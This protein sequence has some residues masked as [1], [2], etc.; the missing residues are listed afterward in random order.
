MS[1]QLIKTYFD[2]R[3][4]SF[5]LF[6]APNG[7]DFS[8]EAEN[9]DNKYTIQSP[10]M[11]LNKGDTLATKF[12]PLRTIV[13]YVAFKVSESAF[14]KSYD[15]AQTRIENIIRDLHSVSNYRGDGIKAVWFSNSKVS[16]VKDYILGEL[17]FTVE[18]QL[19]YV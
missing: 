10:L 17:T 16:T 15:A 11:D 5:L 1:Y 8:G 13:V 12:F 3:L 9:Y 18:D 4:A 2:R 7:I 6:E 19:N 14:T